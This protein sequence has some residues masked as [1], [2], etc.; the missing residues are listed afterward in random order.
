MEMTNGIYEACYF[1]TKQKF[2]IPFM[3]SISEKGPP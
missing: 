1:W 3:D 2:S